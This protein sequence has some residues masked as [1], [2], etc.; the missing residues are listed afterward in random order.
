MLALAAIAAPALAQPKSDWE[1]EYE[2]RSWQE[3]DLVL[4]AY[5]K[6]EDL[7]E[8]FVSAATPFHFYLDGKSLSVGKDGVVRYTL[9]TRSPAGA[10]SVS[11]EGIRCDPAGVR[12]Y[13]Y[14]RTGDRTWSQRPGAWRPIVRM[15]VQRWHLAL[16]S[17]YLCPEQHPIATPAEGVAALRRGGH[18][19]A[20][21]E[22]GPPL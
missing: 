22:I 4:P 16:W 7:V 20:H 18:P 1:V 12:T 15:E 11:Y 21:P 3:A 19:D 8:F 10:V 14:G 6:N 9:V 13:A 2:K 5:P 17:E